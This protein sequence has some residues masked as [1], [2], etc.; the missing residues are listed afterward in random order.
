[1]TRFVTPNNMGR[2]LNQN[3]ATKKYD[4][5]NADVW[6]RQTDNT[7]PESESD[8][9][10]R[11]GNVAVK[12][13]LAIRK[14]ADVPVTATIAAAN[15]SLIRLTSGGTIHGI[16]G[17]ED[18]Q[19]LT[20]MNTSP[21]SVEIRG[22]SSI[23]AAGTAIAIDVSANFVLA[24]NAGVL[25]Q[26]DAVSAV[27]RIVSGAV[28]AYANSALYGQIGSSPQTVTTATDLQLSQVRLM[29]SDITLSG[30]VITLKGGRT[31]ELSAQILAD[32]SATGVEFRAFW[33]NSSNVNI[34]QSE[35]VY[36]P[37]TSPSS[38]G[39]SNHPVAVIAP[40]SDIQVKLR[41]SITGGTASVFAGH[42]T[43][44]ARVIEGL[45]PSKD[46]KLY[47]RVLFGAQLDPNTPPV[48]A[49]AIDGETYIQTTEGTANGT[50]LGTPLASWKYAG[51]KWHRETG[52]GLQSSTAAPAAV[53]NYI[54]Q[55]LV[56][57][58]FKATNRPYGGFTARPTGFTAAEI[59]SMGFTA[60]GG[61]GIVD[62]GSNY[63][64]V[65]GRALIATATRAVNS[66]T[67]TG[68][69]P[70]APPTSY[71]RHEVPA[72]A[73]GKDM[74]YMLQFITGG[75]ARGLGVEVWVCDPTSGAPAKRLYANT[76]PMQGDTNALAN[77]QPLYLAPDNT[78]C[79]SD[80]YR[81]W[82]HWAVPASVVAT[83]KTSSNMIRFALRP[84]VDNGE[85][86][87]FNITDYA[88]AE[89]NHGHVV[90]GSMN[91]GNTV[92]S[93]GAR[94]VT[95]G[96]NML[97]WYANTNGLSSSY[98]PAGR[99][100]VLEIPIV[101]TTKDLYVTM[102]SNM[103]TDK[104]EGWGLSKTHWILK[105]TSGDVV[106]GTPRLD[107]T[108]PSARRIYSH[109]RAMGV[110]IPATVIAAK[111][112]T[113]H[114][115]SVQQYL[116]IEVVCPSTGFNAHITGVLVEEYSLELGRND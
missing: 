25:L 59:A 95:T 78:T 66:A 6:V 52:F 63:G 15:K 10:H 24:P 17:G 112:T 103:D 84:A 31:Y 99:T 64:M 85:N 11:T 12:Q 33:A 65:S 77:Q 46:V 30:N 108:A 49:D 38:L 89:L 19:L 70:F 92:N 42:S 80:Y 47:S 28:L 101:S 91:F 4:V 21:A 93:V 90:L 13:N 67:V 104:P 8:A 83:Y 27:W 105:H 1:M 72:T 60:V 96:G 76:T 102:L 50:P 29:G 40:V 81:C 34:G 73:A 23:A 18:G 26:Y 5:A 55:V 113:Q 45:Q 41:A 116:M 111:A 32:F 114:T 39:S 37:L 36:R 35:G 115:N 75:L 7:I 51:G 94:S 16:S 107:I 57:A 44:T 100:R 54:G 3:P 43:F 56:T 48:A 88:V 87:A 2:G 69:H 97:T 98:V 20:L 74:A 68:T 61:A 82:M 14:S 71:I 53:R 79:N 110:V 58:P 86:T 9:I 106:L 109:H 62:Y 22:F